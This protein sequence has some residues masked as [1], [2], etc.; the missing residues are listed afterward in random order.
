MRRLVVIVALGLGSLVNAACADD[1]PDVVE[2]TAPPPPTSSTTTTPP[3][4]AEPAGSTTAPP[5][6]VTIA[7][8]NGWRL[9]IS[10][11]TSGA[12]VGR[13]TELCVDATGPAREPVIAFDIA[14]LD[15]GESSGST[16]VRV[17]GRIGKGRVLVA[18]PSLPS[19]SYDL[20][21]QLVADGDQV[22]NLAVRVPI[23]LADAAP[24]SLP[25]T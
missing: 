20:S 14:L 16:P 9:V 4:T 13:T 2:T 22:E 6:G 25:C 17:D 21:I 18:L 5:T 24:S 8:S 12:T 19:G 10:Q 3:T 15:P 23:T 7:E 11:P 1:P